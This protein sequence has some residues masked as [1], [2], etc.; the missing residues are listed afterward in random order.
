M[1]TWNGTILGPHGTAHE[2]R[3]YS[4]K[5]FCDQHSPEQP[6]LVKFTSR[7]DIACVKCVAHAAVQAPG[8]RAARRGARQRGNSAR[9][10]PF[11][12]RALTPRAPRSPRDGT[13][14]A[15]TFPV[16]A[17]WRREY[18]MET[19]LLELRREMTSPANRA[20]RQPPEGSCF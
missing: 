11:G 1:R 14:E 17:N 2:N 13:V 9:R 7:I 8:R 20:R 16:L 18:T 5:L 19:I 6:P 12:C 3:I 4:L 10:V 15:R